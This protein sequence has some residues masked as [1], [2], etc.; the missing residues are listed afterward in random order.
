MGEDRQLS[1]FYIWWIKLRLRLHRSLRIP[2]P[3]RV[4]L[5]KQIEP[6][7]WGDRVWFKRDQ[8]ERV[9]EHLGL[10]IPPGTGW[11][12]NYDGDR[13]WARAEASVDLEGLVTA[14]TPED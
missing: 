13:A 12:F 5:Y 11:G 7:E 14:A 1:R 10:C 4:E 6:V 3:R 9:I 8:V 2:L